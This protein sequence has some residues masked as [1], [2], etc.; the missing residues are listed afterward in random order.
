MSTSK[1]K[2]SLS[3]INQQKL[4]SLKN[5]RETID[6]ENEKERLNF[7]NQFHKAIK[8]WTGVFP[9]LRDYFQP[10]QIECILL[11][12][13]DCARGFL[14]PTETYSRG[15]RICEFVAQCDFNNESKADK[16]DKSLL[17]RTTV[18]HRV[19]TNGHPREDKL[20]VDII[21][22]LFKVYNKFDVNYIDQSGLS[23]F[24]VAVMSGCHE[25]VKRFLELGQD[26][27][28][29]PQNS[30]EPPLHLALT[31]KRKEVVKLL[32]DHGADPNMLNQ[33]GLTPLQNIIKQ[34]PNKIRDSSARMLFNFSNK[35]YRPVQV[36]TRDPDGSGNTLLHLA[37][38]YE[39]KEL[40]KFLL[41]KGAN[42][43]IANEEGLTPLH[44]TLKLKDRSFL[45]NHFFKLSKKKYRSMLVN[46]LDKKG[47][48][49]LHLFATHFDCYLSTELVESL[50]RNGSD[51]NLANE[52][53]STP[54]HYFCKINLEDSLECINI[55]FKISDELNKTIQVD[56]RDKSGR[57]PLQYA[58]V[59]F[60]PD[61][62]EVLLD[63]GA[64]LSSFFFPQN[65]LG[66]KWI[67]YKE[68]DYHKLT[69]AAGAM[70]VIEKLRKR[71]YI[72]DRSDALTIMKLFAHYEMY[73]KSTDFEKS[74]RDDEDFVREAKELTIFPSPMKR[75]NPTNKISNIPYI[76]VFDLPRIAG[77]VD[78][79]EEMVDR[80]EGMVDRIEIEGPT[81]KD[82]KR[83]SLYDLLQLRPEEVVKICTH[84]K[85][86][87][88]CFSKIDLLS[89]RLR[90]ACVMHLCDK[91]TKGFFRSWALDFYWEL[92]G[93]RMPMECC[94]M[95]IDESI[96]NENLYNICL[97]TELKI[98][99]LEDGEK[100]VQSS[101]VECVKK[102]LKRTKAPKAQKAVK[103][104]KT[105]E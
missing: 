49:P 46:G 3:L 11:D 48:T 80:I 88:L 16:N 35:K 32:L 92:I 75:T 103:R 22:N 69:L 7:L 98:K 31:Y 43:T 42:P 14:K 27:N 73:E 58:V 65:C 63:R 45:A 26:P 38:L 104:Q 39:C 72:L 18:I 99:S 37:I 23:H 24:H 1:D 6:W 20:F 60:I 91:I 41:R 54:L 101:E 105:K 78:S 8:N 9:D 81:L 66:E 33:E 100:K 79:F 34:G 84:E 97:A 15:K 64:D 44:L 76:S 56:A 13:L 70:G 47:N 4:E 2:S 51:P 94:E 95:I 71:E 67:W 30:L 21:S 89:E 10:E 87:D 102:G 74:W 85:D 12:S 82:D 93:Y 77:M 83:T 40:F 86:I 28:Y 57:T 52:E 19:A 55:L 61:V 36:D 53:G 5:L 17:R 29:P 90:H 62:V 68:D 25:V 96:T 59:N 50:L